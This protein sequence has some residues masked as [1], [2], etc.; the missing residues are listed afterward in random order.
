MSKYYILIEL[1]NDKKNT[2]S[3]CDIFSFY[4]NFSDNPF[5]SFRLKSRLLY[6]IFSCFLLFYSLKDLI[7]VFKQKCL[8]LSILLLWLLVLLFCLAKGLSHNLRAD[9]FLQYPL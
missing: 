4:L 1:M 9:S 8:Y 7:G 5:S 3:S 2:N 6:G